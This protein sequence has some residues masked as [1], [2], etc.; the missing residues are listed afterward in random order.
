MIRSVP[1]LVLSYVFFFS[2]NTVVCSNRKWCVI[3]TKASIAKGSSTKELKILIE[4]C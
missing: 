4:A 3:S 1:L 2:I